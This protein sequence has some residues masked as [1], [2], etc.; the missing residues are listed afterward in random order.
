M[1]RASIANGSVVG[2]RR[3][4]IYH[5]PDCPDYG[6]VVPQNRVPCGSAAEAE[7]AGYRLARNCP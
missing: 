6:A 5:R 4:R 1:P 2:N 3:S 7:S